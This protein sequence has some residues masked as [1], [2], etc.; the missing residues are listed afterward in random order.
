MRRRLLVVAATIREGSMDT[1]PGSQGAPGGKDL[2]A[3]WM[4]LT[5][6]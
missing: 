3:R 6:Q 4:D 5:T 2:L 1:P